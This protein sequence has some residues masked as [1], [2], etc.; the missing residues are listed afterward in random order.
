MSKKID[1]LANA[2]YNTQLSS[3]SEATMGV[4]A[5]KIGFNKC[6]ELVKPLLKES[7]E[8]LSDLENLADGYEE[9]SLKLNKFLSE[10]EQ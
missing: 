1:N 2:E 3:M 5:F 9:T 4:V 7:I 8:A 10:Y 6:F